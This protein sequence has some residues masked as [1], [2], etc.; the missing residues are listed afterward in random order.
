MKVNNKRLT[1]REVEKF[2]GT[3]KKLEIVKITNRH[4]EIE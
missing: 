4:I 1:N 2:V 3:G